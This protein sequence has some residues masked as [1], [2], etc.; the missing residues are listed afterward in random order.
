MF[1]SFEGSEG[2]GK[3][4][5]VARLA[6][7]LQGLG[8]PVRVLREPGGTPLGEEL[9]HTLKHSPAGAGMTAEAELL[10][11]NAARAQLV[12]AVIR[13]ALDA[14]EVVLCDRFFDSTVAYQGWGRGLDLANVQHVVH[15]AV[16]STRPRLTLLL[17]L[18]VEVRAQRVHARAAG[19]AAP[20][21]RFEAEAAE[22]FAKVEAGFEAVARENPERVR[23]V[24]A[25]GTLEEVEARIWA[26][27]E[28]VLRTAGRLPNAGH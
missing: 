6:S 1:L 19:A 27:V 21:D 5:Q 22:F 11:M 8:V 14:G 9:R 26:V 16:G 25:D 28:P 18:P 23:V 17:R 15:F 24:S 3:S 20:G 13:P 4:T 12:R 2:A 7:R 10:L